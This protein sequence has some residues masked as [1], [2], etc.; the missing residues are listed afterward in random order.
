MTR[1]AGLSSAASV[2]SAIEADLS[3]LSTRNTPNMRAVRRLYSSK[4]RPAAPELILGLAA[5]LC[6]GEDRWFGYELIAAHRAAF[7]RLGPEEIEQLGQGI[8]SWWTVD[9]FARI[10]SGPAWRNGQAPDKL[11]FKWAH[12]PDRWWRRAALVSTVALN[13][14]A[15]GGKGDVRR[16]LRIC[17]VLANDNDD[18]VAKAMSWAL[19]ALVPHDRAAVSRFLEEYDGVLPALVKREVNNKLKTGLKTG[20]V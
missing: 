9:A 6:T 1:Q 14:P 18:M 5:V 17:R 20:R 19:R 13:M 3:A 15:Q 2:A 8:N 7:E 10:L 12:S 4:L 11:I 16:T